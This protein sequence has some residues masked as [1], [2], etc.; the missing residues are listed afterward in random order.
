[1]RTTKFKELINNHS[2]HEIVWKIIKGDLRLN[3]LDSEKR[4]TKEQY[5][6]ILNMKD[7]SDK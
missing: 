6:R 5:K 7:R 2:K 3:S 4:I 1:M